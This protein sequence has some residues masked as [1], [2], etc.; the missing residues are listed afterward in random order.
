MVW[1]LVISNTFLTSSRG[2]NNTILPPRVE[3][4]L[5]FIVNIRMPMEVKIHPGEVHE[6]AD[7]V[8][9]AAGCKFLVNAVEA[10]RV[11]AADQFD[12][13]DAIFYLA[14]LEF[15]VSHLL[16]GYVSPLY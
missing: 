11:Q 14:V 7:V 5:A 16:V 15:H 9:R 12:E 1:M 2:L 3:S 4:D 6:H 8:T 10:C 13:A